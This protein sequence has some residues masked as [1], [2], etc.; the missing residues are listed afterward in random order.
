RHISLIGRRGD[1]VAS[2]QAD[3]SYE[4][5]EL[6]HVHSF[7]L[8]LLGGQNMRLAWHGLTDSMFVCRRTT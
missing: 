5:F 4:Q 3:K 7:L 6:S 2:E 1:D 8:S